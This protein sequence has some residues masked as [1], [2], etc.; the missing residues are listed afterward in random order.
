MHCSLLEDGGACLFL[1]MDIRER[2]VIWWYGNGESSG[3]NVGK[4]WRKWENSY[5]YA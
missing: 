5:N 3:I 1:T 4:W 2:S